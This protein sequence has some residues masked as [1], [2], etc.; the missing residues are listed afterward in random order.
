VAAAPA[1]ARGSLFPKP[2]KN[3]RHA[4]NIFKKTFF[5]KEHK[6]NGKCKFAGSRKIIEK[7]RS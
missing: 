3:T 4:K 1:D 2:C 5:A 7:M 6:L